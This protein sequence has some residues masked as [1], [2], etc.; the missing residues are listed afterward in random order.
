MGTIID[1]SQ[2]NTVEDWDA[3]KGAV[4][5]VILRCGYTLS[6]QKDLTVCVDHKYP[7]YRAACEARGIPCTVIPQANHSLESG[8]VF[9]D[10]KELYR[11]MEKTERFISEDKAE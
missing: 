7:V 10:L 2:W 1:V 5:A 6:T 11:I 8:D 3:V 9:S 4:D